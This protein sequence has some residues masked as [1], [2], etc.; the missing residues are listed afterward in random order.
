MNNQP[1]E[2]A[3]VG[4]TTV[5]AIAAAAGSQLI[6]LDPVAYVAEVFRPYN[7]MFAILKAEADTITP[8]ASTPA[9]MEICI[10]YR[11][12]FRDD[13]RVAGEKARVE[14]KA[15][16]LTIGKLLDSKYADLKNAVIPYEAKFDAA[17]KAEEKRKDDLKKAEAEREEKVRQR[18]V[19][20]RELPLAT[21]GK[22]AAVIAEMIA[23]LEADLPDESFGK[24]QDA[25]VTARADVLVKLAGL[26]AAAVASEEEAAR[27]AA[28][29]AELAQLREAAAERQRLALEQADRVAAAQ[30]AEADRLAALA[31]EQEAAALRER[32]AAAAQ[33]KAEA[34]AQAEKNR[35]AQAE[36]DRQLAELAAARQADANRVAAEQA[37]VA[38]EAQAA[39][40]RHAAADQA[41]CDRAAAEQQAAALAEQG[42]LTDLA[43]MA[44]AATPTACQPVRIEV[45]ETAPA[46]PPTLRLGQISDRLG[47]AV[48]AVFLETLG[49]APAATDK[50]AKLYH[51]A[52]F[53]G[54]CS[55]LRRHIA[56]VQAAHA[57]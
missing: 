38:A 40:D 1:N 24:L 39:A 31:A 45:R 32:E 46:G 42:R 12:A 13:V 55:A 49:F 47:F 14:R 56:D 41:E 26:R 27:I 19:N 18:I 30:K 2:I 37:R 51:E 9:G 33:L 11:A 44:A 48:T 22:S 21:V 29:R 6:T 10:K 53:P 43:D 25:A 15:P 20:I 57:V 7:D 5:Q 16:I 4:A 36:I 52:D 8:D 34:D 28:E 35:L 50:A 54:M 3:A 23:A 17:I